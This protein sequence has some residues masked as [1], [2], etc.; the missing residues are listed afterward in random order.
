MPPP[1]T[2]KEPDKTVHLSAEIT[3]RRKEVWEALETAQTSRSFEGRGNK[4]FAA[5]TAER[6][7]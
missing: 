5:D 7:E 6:G 2:H 1:S 4:G 3:V